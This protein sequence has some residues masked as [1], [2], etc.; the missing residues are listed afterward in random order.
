M[1]IQ[2][3][4]EIR[5]AINTDA[6]KDGCVGMSGDD[7]LA[8]AVKL[9]I[10]IIHKYEGYDLLRSRVEASRFMEGK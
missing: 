4:I 10:T 2:T 9:A 5:K 3:Q 6:C 7:L 8:R 1:R